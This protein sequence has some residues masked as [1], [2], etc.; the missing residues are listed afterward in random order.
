MEVD[1]NLIEMAYE[2]LSPT[3]RKF[4]KGLLTFST[5]FSLYHFYGYKIEKLPVGEVSYGMPSSLLDSILLIGIIYLLISYM[6]YL[7]DD[8]YNE[9]E[10]FV[11][12]DTKRKIDELKIQ[13]EEKL[14]KVIDEYGS[15]WK[16][17][18]NTVKGFR[19]LVA[20]TVLLG[21]FKKENFEP[22][23][24]NSL[25]GEEGENRGLQMITILIK[26]HREMLK[27]NGIKNIIKKVLLI[28]RS[29]QVW[30]F[31]MP[32]VASFIALLSPLIVGF[33]R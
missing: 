31:Y 27:K 21:G 11:E 8:I 2:P 15:L 7:M 26:S 12:T 24:R 6:I 5:T 32:V 33:F 4:R 23:F 19:R 1:Q 13:F 30:D 16:A 17:N 10:R 18:E 3:T 28:K 25:Y 20:S 14:N 22:Y 29:R 9:G